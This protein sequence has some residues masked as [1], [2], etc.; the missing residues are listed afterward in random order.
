MLDLA[1]APVVDVHCHPWRNDALLDADP[2]RFED[3]VTMM[4]M[5]LLSSGMAAG[6]REEHLRMLTDSTPM[7]LRL[8]RELATYLGCGPSREAVAEARHTQLAADPPGYIRGLLDDA[9]VVG[10]V[11]D[12]GYPQP[13]ISYDDFSAATRTTLYRVARIEPWIAALRDQARTFDELE[14]AFIAELDRAAADPHMVAYKS[15]I[16][17][18]TGLDVGAPSRDESRSAFQQWREDGFRESRE[19]AKPV[20]DALLRR[21]LE[22]G[23]R[24]DRPLHIHC[25][26]GDPDVVLSHA[27]PQDL[28]PLL[29]EHLG[30]PI[31]LIHSGWPWIEEA[32]YIASILPYVYLDMSVLVPWGSLAIDQ[33]LE[34]LLG[35]APCAKVLYGSDEASEPEVL[36]LA[37]RVGREALERVLSV[38]VERRWLSEPEAQRMGRGILAENALRLHGMAG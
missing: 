4:G 30:Q 18:R 37:A 6:T 31:V 36:W 23:K 20:R 27:H 10:L 11:Y 2:E 29:R 24:H 3:R 35:A 14:D 16:A 17:Y 8:R 28:F 22:A 38:A 5:C 12:E 7:A 1:D 26:G 33:K 13:T 9:N 19:H 25:G 21:A 15:V 32:A 34:V